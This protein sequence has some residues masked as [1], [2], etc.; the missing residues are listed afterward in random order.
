[1][2]FQVERRR[3]GGHELHLIAEDERLRACLR[4]AS[5]LAAEPLSQH[6]ASSGSSSSISR[7][8]SANPLPTASADCQF[9]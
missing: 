6:Q 5:R 8:T 9:S 2:G 1:M 3:G 4:L 7:P